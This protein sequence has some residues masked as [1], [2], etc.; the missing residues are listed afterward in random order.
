MSDDL[1]SR[2]ESE[3]RRWLGEMER[4]GYAT[5]AARFANRMAVIDRTPYPEDEFVRA[6]LR[7]K[8]AATDRRVARQVAIAVI[9]MIAACIAAWPVI[10][11]WIR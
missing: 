4:L 1:K 11:E 10:K 3:E 5:V 2:R 8:E 6:W 7:E 9:T